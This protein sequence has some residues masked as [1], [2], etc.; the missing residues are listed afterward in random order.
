MR[1]RYG[2]SSSRIQLDFEFQS[3]S[4]VPTMHVGTLFHIYISDKGLSECQW[5]SDIKEH[6]ILTLYDM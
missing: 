2:S 3:T 6:K 4:E 5:I 1:H